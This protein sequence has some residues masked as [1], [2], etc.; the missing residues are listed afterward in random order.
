MKCISIIIFLYLYKKFLS[1]CIPD[2]NCFKN[3]GE[4]V[5]NYCK[6]YRDFWT[7]KSNEESNINFIYC[8]YERKSRFVP[9]ISE[10]FIPGLGHFLV[11][12]NKKGII[13]ILLLLTPIILILIGYSIFKSEELNEKSNNDSENEEELN[14]INNEEKKENNQINQENKKDSY[15]SDEGNE[16]INIPEK[17]HFANHDKKP[18]PCLQSF[19]LFVQLFC[20]I[21]FVIM[22]II[23]IIG[24][25]LAFYKDG[26]KVPLL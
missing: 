25:G 2:K 11:G 24:Y 19:L 22:Y 4:C 7:L 8:N 12:N 13:K 16:V 20:L 17:L 1:E 3:R 23:D 26:N 18:I 14:L 9:L 15:F 5:N 6:C 10:I 21:G